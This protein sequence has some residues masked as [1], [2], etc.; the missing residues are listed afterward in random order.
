VGRFYPNQCSQAQ[1]ENGDL[2]VRFSG[3]GYAYTNVTKKLSFT[4]SGA[5]Q[6]NQDFLVADDACDVY[7]YFR[8]RQVLASDF[9]INK[10]EQPVA[11]Y[12]SQLTPM[13]ED[14]GKQLVSGQLKDGF[15]VIQLADGNTDFGPGI[16]E[17]GKRPFHPMMAGG[18]DRI[19]YQNDRTEIHR[20]ERDFVG[21]IEVKEGGRALYI[22]AKTDGGVALDVLVLAKQAGDQALQQYLEVPQAGPLPQNAL[23]ADVVPA[24]ALGF[25][26]R[27]AVQP[28][29]YYVVFDNTSSAG[30]TMPQ[31]AATEDRAAL[32]DYSVQIGE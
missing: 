23:W 21:P 18:K 16:V 20:E 2:S 3:A 13:G 28:G 17:L 22:N 11:A 6:Y 8:P 29:F 9:K 27:V 26:R 1:L 25:Q 14:F 32:L 10:I 19:T 24:Q 4:M 15:T 12:F 7:G 31:G 5:V 30:A